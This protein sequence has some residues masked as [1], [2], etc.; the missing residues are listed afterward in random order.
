MV[1]VTGETLWQKTQLKTTAAAVEERKKSY[2]SSEVPTRLATMTLRSPPDVVVPWLP[3]MALPDRICHEGAVSVP[4]PAAPE[5]RSVR[6]A[7]SRYRRTRSRLWTLPQAE[8]T[9]RRTCSRSGERR[10]RIDRHP[11]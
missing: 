2:H 7:A 6:G 5:R 9:R 11:R 4:G 8:C 3:V 10:T 1:A